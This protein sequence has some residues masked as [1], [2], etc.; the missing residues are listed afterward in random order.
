MVTTHL[1]GKAD[2]STSVPMD[3]F[4]LREYQDVL[5]VV[6]QKQETILQLTVAQVNSALTHHA[7][8]PIHQAIANISLI[9]PL[10][11]LLLLL[12]L[13]ALTHHASSLINQAI[14][15]I[16]LIALV[17]ALKESVKL[18]KL[19]VIH[20]VAVLQV[21]EGQEVQV[22]QED[23][24]DLEDQDN[25]QTKMTHQMKLTVQTQIQAQL[26]PAQRAMIQNVLSKGLN[27]VIAKKS[28]VAMVLMKVEVEQPI[29]QPRQQDQDFTIAQ[30][31]ITQ[32]LDLVDA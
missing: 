32:Q 14:A 2:A 13:S 3:N 16:S 7:S 6:L 26:F 28:L 24:E 11:L 18:R 31:V 22:V 15:K 23:R 19:E 1:L 5:V 12:L 20:Q 8:S 17:P 4:L 10:L 29:S 21:Q 9:A 30:M 25:H 27:Q